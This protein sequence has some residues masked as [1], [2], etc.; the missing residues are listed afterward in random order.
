MSMK[1]A[2]VTTTI[3]P[4][5]EAIKKF[6][7]IAEADDWK[8]FVV[9]DQKTPHEDY[10]NLAFH[11]DCVEYLAPEEQEEMSKELSDLI[12]W[13]CIQRRNFG[14]MAAYKWG[15]DVIATIDDDNIPYSKWG[16]NLRVGKTEGVSIFKTPLNVFDPLSPTHP[17]LWH[18]GFPIQLLGEREISKPQLLTRKIL[19]Q[20]DMWDGAPDIDAVARITLD[21]TVTFNPNLI[22]YASNVM[23]PFNSQNTFLSREVFPEY[24][25]FPH[26]GRMDDIF[27][28]YLVQAY[29]P[30]SV[31]YSRASVFQDRN[32]HDLAKDLEAELIG[33]KHALDFVNWA[34]S[35]VEGQAMKWPDFMPASAVAAYEVYVKWFKGA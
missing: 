22:P 27:A 28:S 7:N 33:Y 29:F 26:I 6:I 14:L 8:M 5:T 17:E 23:G 2:I 18:R 16:Q 1:K 32:P 19:I 31:I 9:G 12:G 13:N 20:A 15:A 34:Q 25:L 24:F 4:P 30:D 21:P 10:L 3:N 35:L 11:N